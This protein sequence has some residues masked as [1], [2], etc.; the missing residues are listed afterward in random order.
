MVGQIRDVRDRQVR[1]RGAR[2]EIEGPCHIYLLWQMQGRTTRTGCAPSQLR[3]R[4]VPEEFFR[5]CSNFKTQEK[6]EG[7]HFNSVYKDDLT[8]GDK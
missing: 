7:K 3:S 6:E 4:Q 2:S 8:R 5:L 1:D